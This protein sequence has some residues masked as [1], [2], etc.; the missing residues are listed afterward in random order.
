LFHWRRFA[1]LF[2]PSLVNI[3]VAGRAGTGATAFRLNFRHAMVNRRLHDCGTGLAFDGPRSACG[4][5]IG[6]FHHGEMTGRQFRLGRAPGGAMPL[7]ALGSI[8]SRCA[9]PAA[10]RSKT[11]AMPRVGPTVAALLS[12]QWRLRSGWARWARAINPLTMIKRSLPARFPLICQTDR[13]PA[14]GAAWGFF[15]GVPI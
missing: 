1:D 6:N 12:A 10:F 3:D 13:M 2:A 8:G 9:T 5:D 14:G 4:I 11:A 15:W 7:R